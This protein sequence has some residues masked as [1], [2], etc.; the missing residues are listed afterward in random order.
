M[1]T[2]SYGPYYQSSI[3]AKEKQ[4][5]ALTGQG[6]TP[7]ELA[8]LNYGELMARYQEAESR[9]T[10][11]ENKALQERG[12]ELQARGMRTQE[13]AQKAGER[14]ATISGIA[15]GV[16]ILDKVGALS[17][18]GKA[19][20]GALAPGVETVPVAAETAAKA[21]YYYGEGA[22]TEGEG[23]FTSAYN[24]V[25]NFIKSG[26]VICTELYNQGLLDEET[27]RADSKFGS[28]LPEDVLIG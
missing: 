25:S 28:L 4:R 22:A 3:Q 13:K 23:F 16:N 12:L 17:W 10:I 19:I 7:E 21:A 1:A 8:G 27:Y 5:K 9:R 24:T 6:Y 15:T 20:T 18:G 14:A 2:F 11:E 26:T